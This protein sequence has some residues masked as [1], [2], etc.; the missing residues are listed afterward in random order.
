MWFAIIA[1]IAIIYLAARPN[2]HSCCG[3][4]RSSEAE[5]ILKKRFVAGEIDEETYKKMLL[6]LRSN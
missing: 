2:H 3:T 6:T 5:E 1:L 4:S